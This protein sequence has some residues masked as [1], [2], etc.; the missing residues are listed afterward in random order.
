MDTIT[1][2]QE[3]ASK[4][5]GGVLLDKDAYNEDDKEQIRR[6]AATLLRQDITPTGY[7]E[8]VAGSSWGT[9][10][11][12]MEGLMSVIT[13]HTVEHGEVTWRDISS[14]NVSGRWHGLTEMLGLPDV[15]TLVDTDEDV[16]EFISKREDWYLFKVFQLPQVTENGEMAVAIAWFY[17]IVR[18]PRVI[19]CALDGVENDGDT[20]VVASCIFDADNLI[21]EGAAEFLDVLGDIEEEE[22]EEEFDE[23]FDEDGE[24][25]RRRSVEELFGWPWFASAMQERGITELGEYVET[26]QA[27][28]VYW[29]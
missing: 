9:K 27:G 15:E 26:L 17:R 21:D 8:L 22:L 1:P 6:W 2:I 20:S 13:N 18:P 24:R 5:V 11:Y 14:R 23:G 16:R 4:V 3:V 7:A 12:D 10:L 29:G 19:V 28:D 25:M